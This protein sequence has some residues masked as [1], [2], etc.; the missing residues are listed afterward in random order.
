M[1]AQNVKQ[2]LKQNQ[3]STNIQRFI[4]VKNH[5]NVINVI[6]RLP[7]KLTY[8]FIY[9]HILERN[10]MLAQDVEGVSPMSPLSV[11]IVGPTA[12][13]DHISAT[14]VVTNLPKRAL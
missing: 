14:I 10:R 11:D 2:S 9:E 12:E 8:S 13:R 3:N 1:N 5:S 7:E 4:R 6:N